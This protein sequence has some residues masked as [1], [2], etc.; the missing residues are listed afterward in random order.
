MDV[1]IR[2][3]G[4]VQLIQL[5]GEL[6]MGEGLTAFIRATDELLEAGE[7]R[8]VIHLGEVS[9]LDSSGI[10]A[11]VKLLT[12]VSRRGGGLRLVNPSPFATKTLKLVGLLALFPVYADEEQAVASFG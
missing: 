2:K 10:G 6:R 11:L 1:N 4:A 7:V 8:F 5:R 3:R 12:S 9:M